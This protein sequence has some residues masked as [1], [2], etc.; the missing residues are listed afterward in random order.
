MRLPAQDGEVLDRSRSFTFSWNGQPIQAYGGDT[1]LSALT[2]ADF[3][4]I[5]RSFKYHR[6]RGPLTADQH[7]PNCFV[8]VDGEPNMPAGHVL[9]TPGMVVK[10]Q[11]A[12]PNL[13][14]D[15]GAANQLIG[16][17]LTAGFYYKTF[18]R[19]RALRTS[20]QRVLRKFSPGGALPSPTPDEYYEKR[21]IFHDVVVA[22][23]G[24]A[25]LAAAIA[26]AEQGARVLVVEEEHQV[27][28]HLRWGSTHERKVLA[29]LRRRVEELPNLQVLTNSV[30][31]GRYDHNWVAVYERSPGGRATERLHK[32]RA[33]TIVVATGALERPYVFKGNDLPGV[34]L[35]TAV[36][37]LVNMYAVKPGERA[38]VLIGNADGDAAANCL[39]AAGVDVT[40]IDA[41]RGVTVRSATGSGRV[42]QVALS[43]GR[44]LPADLLVTAAGW[45]SQS[46]LLSMAGVPLTYSEPLGR[47]VCANSGRADVVV[48]GGLAGEASL[49]DL[50]QQAGKAGVAAAAG[51]V[52]TAMLNTQQPQSVPLFSAGTNGIIDFSEDVSESDMQGAVREGYSSIELAKRYTTATM[53][54]TQ[55]KYSAINAAA[56]HAEVTGRSVADTGIPT[57]R[58]PYTPVTLGALAGRRFHP[59]RYTPMHR[60]HVQAGATFM[61]AGQWVRPQ[62]YGNAVDEARNVRN[63]VGIIDV[64]TLGKIEL[65]GSDVPRLLEAFYVNK[66]SK[67]A[68][69]SVRYGVMCADDGIVFDDGVT[70]RIDEN[71]YLMSATSS[72]T[73]KV[74]D[75]IN[76]WLQT[77]GVGADVVAIPVTDAYAGINVAGPSARD[78]LQRVLQSPDISAEAFR[79]M[80]IS[81]ATIAGVPGCYMW[82]IGFTGELSY[83]IHIPAA[84]GFHVWNE[85]LRAGKDLGIRPFGVE[86]QRILRIEK[87]HAVVGQDTDALTGP[88]AAGLGGLV[89][90]DKVEA[91][92]LPELAHQRDSQEHL[93]YVLVGLQPQNGDY[94]PPEASQLVAGGRIIGRVTSSCF[95]PTLERSIALALVNPAYAK[96]YDAVSIRR[97]DSGLEPATVMPTLTHVDPEGR[98]LHV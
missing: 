28:G 75:A 31:L 7:D 58:P 79:Y 36:R 4:V 3:R 90:F 86:A 6:P 54:P 37:R 78:L 42:E 97:T 32:G 88:Y 98:R 83:E 95:S 10:A 26:A 16:R 60:W 87:G 14:Y 35:S 93:P 76:M 72:G 53:G 80:R 77:D 94:V 11:N 50:I 1:V 24:P 81:E 85:L 49:D 63:G 38:V 89:R 66:W 41:R 33:R 69:G 82:R 5:S 84:F 96:A 51:E 44:T 19:P 25:G 39:E 61:H 73:Q 67:L 22:G 18:M 23:A 45:T 91:T 43:D 70:G 59:L 52:A 2:A 20:Y 27:G 56:V 13:K 17:F 68:V 8:T 12:W 65:R 40:R 46:S 48:V 29:D 47:F 34:M 64:S 55:G 57:W 30:L 21:F 15:V 71:R 92:G 62:H 9:A 74:V